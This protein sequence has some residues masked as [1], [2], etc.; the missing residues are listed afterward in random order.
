LEIIAIEGYRTCVR[1]GDFNV[2]D[3]AVF[4]EPDTI[5]DTTRPEFAFLEGQAKQSRY[6]I[7]AVRLRGEQSFGLLIPAP[8]GL[9]ED[10]DAWEILGLEHYDPPE[11]NMQI[12]NTENYHAPSVPHV[13][14]D[15]ENMKKHMELIEDGELVEITEKI[16]GCNARYVYH[17]GELFVGSHGNWKKEDERN[18]WWRIAAQYDLRTILAQYPDHVLYGEVY[19]Q[20]Q[21]LKY[22]AGKEQ[23]FLA[24]FDIMREGQWLSPTEVSAWCLDTGVPHV[25]V[26]YS[27]PWST[28]LMQLA[29]GKTTVAGATHLREGIVIK[30]LTPRTHVRWGRVIAKVVSVDYLARKTK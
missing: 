25:P 19:G 10:V 7:R 21:D 4:L 16:H 22:G 5:V 1:L 18:L 28:D 2:G 26:L 23:V 12:Q 27:G 3:L 13:R 11:P 14:Y 20:V 15:M 17:D 6:R 8:D 9:V 30:P 29:D 24:I